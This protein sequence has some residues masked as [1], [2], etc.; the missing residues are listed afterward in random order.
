L[1]THASIPMLDVR[2]A[3]DT[4]ECSRL[5]PIIRHPVNRRGKHTTHG[6]SANTLTGGRTAWSSSVTIN[7]QGYQARYWYAGDHANN[8]R[9]DAAEVALQR[10]GIVPTPRSPYAQ[11][12]PATQ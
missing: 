3:R 7:G 5:R 11:Q 12:N 10:M 9:E 2:T 4:L 6:T 8:A 1:H